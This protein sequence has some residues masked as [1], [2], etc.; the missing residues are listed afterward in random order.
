[1]KI[2]KMLLL[3]A[4][5]VGVAYLINKSK[6]PEKKASEVT[7]QKYAGQK[8]LGLYPARTTLAPTYSPATTAGIA[9]GRHKWKS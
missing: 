1:M 4:G 5:I 7:G 3:G 9:R 8:A 6:Q 2:G